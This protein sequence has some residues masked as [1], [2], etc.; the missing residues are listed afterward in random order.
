MAI[1]TASTPLL[2]GLRRCAASLFYH[3]DGVRD[4]WI[5]GNVFQRAIQAPAPVRVFAGGPRQ[6]RLFS[7]VG[8]IVQLHRKQ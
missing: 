8:K 2:N 1:N 6:V 4:R 7:L 3:R 5:G